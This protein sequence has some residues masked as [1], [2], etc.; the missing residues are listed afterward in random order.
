[1]YQLPHEILKTA[2]TLLAAIH[3]LQQEKG[4]ESSMTFL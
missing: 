2:K 4:Q 1:M 3:T